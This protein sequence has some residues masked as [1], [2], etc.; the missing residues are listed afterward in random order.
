WVSAAPDQFDLDGAV[1]RRADGELRAFMQALA[2][3]LEGALPGRVTVERRR[4]GLFA[5]TS[6]VASISVRGDKALY[7]LGFDKGNLTATRAKF[8]RG[9]SIS[10]STIPAREWLGEVGDELNALAEEAGSASDAL[11]GFL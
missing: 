3:R 11:H 2:V 5:R 7:E 10:S 1:L 4:D 6:H 9:V 8:V